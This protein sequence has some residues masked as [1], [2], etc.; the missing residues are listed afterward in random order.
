MSNTADLE[1][2][3]D[4]VRK[5]AEPRLAAGTTLKIT[6]LDLDFVGDIRPDKD[7]I[8]VMSSVTSP[9]A[10]LKYE[11]LG[12]NG[13]VLKEGERRLS[14]MNYQQ[15]VSPLGRNEPLSYEKQLLKDWITREF[16]SKS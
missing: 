12:A 13:E 10:H 9:R 7:N 1:E 15:S 11:L 14:D 6:F 5:T 2:L 4:F 16:N 3:R 8:R